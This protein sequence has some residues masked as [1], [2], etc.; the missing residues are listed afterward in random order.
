MTNDDV[1]KELNQ[2][3]HLTDKLIKQLAPTTNL[4]TYPH[5]IQKHT[6]GTKALKLVS[7]GQLQMFFA[8][9]KKNDVPDCER[10][11]LLKEFLV[12]QECDLPFQ[13]AQAYREGLL[14][15]AI[16][17]NEHYPTEKYLGDG[18]PNPQ[19]LQLEAT[20]LGAGL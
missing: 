10:D 14:N 3:R 5:Q 19:W 13:Q 9:R 15:L 4:P 18:E 2:I 12:K 20:V 7:Q 17:Y 11:E 1:L 6:H 16:Q 8:I